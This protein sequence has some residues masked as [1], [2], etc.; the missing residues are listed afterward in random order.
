MTD[1]SRR[2]GWKRAWPPGIAGQLVILVIVAILAIHAVLTLSFIV[3]STGSRP[4]PA[5]TT[6]R[7]AAVVELLD[8]AGPLQRPALLG[9]VRDAFPEFRVALA[10]AG[11]TFHEE[12]RPAPDARHLARLLGT[13]FSVSS[14]RGD[15]AGPDP[16]DAGLLVRL[17]DGAMLLLSSPR[18]SPPP[19]GPLA[20][21]IGFIAISAVLL[22]T[23]AVLA[24]TKPLRAIEAQV[25]AYGPGQTFSPLPEAGPREI[26]TLARAFNRMQERISRLM[27]DR[28]R[29][30]AAVGHDLRTPITRLRLRAEL[31]DDSP[32]KARMMAD[33]DQM[34][35]LVQSA[36]THLRDGRGDEASSTLD[37]QSLLQTIADGYADIG[38]PVGMAASARLA[39]R[40]RA[41]ELERA[42]TNIVD[43]AIK[44]GGGASLSLRREG[45]RAVI[46][47]A[48]R[49]PGIPHEMRAAVLEPF[50]R[51]EVA[52]T[53]NETD[54]FGL[55]LTI[56]RSIIEAHDGAITFADGSPAGFVVRMSL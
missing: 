15:V 12:T 32:E 54:G 34:A 55:G 18:P 9:V 13:G 46:E 27:D 23:W 17:R 14:L 5:E 40:G 37:L 21:T 4:H 52:R 47:V 33:L 45:D 16:G 7:Q 36:L 11:A 49:G 35:A 8:R 51:G 39:I 25:E 28:T 31:L 20:L 50:V 48:D 3:A 38:K 42:I 44:Y 1:N 19:G 24:L 22:G 53:M 6:G 41:L 43:N 29:T 26:R 2:T 30:L 10:S 56:A